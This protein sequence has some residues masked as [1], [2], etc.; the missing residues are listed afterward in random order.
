[1]STVQLVAV[2]VLLST[3]LSI[4]SFAGGGDVGKGALEIAHEVTEYVMSTASFMEKLLSY[5]YKSKMLWTGVALSVA[6]QLRTRMRKLQKSSWYT[7]EA[8]S[9][10]VT[11]TKFL[12]FRMM[13]DKYATIVGEDNEIVR[14]GE[15]SFYE[16]DGLCGVCVGIL[17]SSPEVSL[18]KT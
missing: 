13:Q 14:Q 5:L 9:A 4:M 11:T 8:T 18:T 10:N 3:G 17:I 1:M 7:S 6:W 2:A 12:E 16:W 15:I